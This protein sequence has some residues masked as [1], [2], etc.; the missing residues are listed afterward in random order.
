[1]QTLP[2]SCRRRQTPKLIL[3]GHHNPDT[4][5][6]KNATQKE[7][8]R[9]ISLMNIDAK[10]LK[11]FLET[12]SSNIFKRSYI[13]TKWALFQIC[14]DSSIFTD[15]LMWYTIL[16]NWKIKT[17]WLFQWMQRKPLTKFNSHLWLKTP[18]S[19]HRRNIPQH[20]KN[21]IWQ[22]RSKHYSQ[23]WKIKN[24][25]SK[26]RNKARV[27]TLTTTTQHSFGSPSHSNQRRKRNKRNLDLKKRSK[28]LTVCKWHDPLHRKP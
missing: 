4:K 7:N 11:K 23:W 24:I 27:P 1:M 2:E 20:N 22:T 19:R 28:T 21:N 10:V 3:W 17:I 9:L 16:T 18:E 5:P 8:Y 12:E 15:K 26:I 13:M 6:D 14:K 25:S